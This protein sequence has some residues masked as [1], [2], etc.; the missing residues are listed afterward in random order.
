MNIVATIAQELDKSE[1]QIQAAI[2]LLD[3]GA[4]VPFIARYRKEQTNGLDDT[5]LRSLETRLQYLREFNERK[6]QIL[7]S[8]TEQEKL[9]PDLKKAIDAATSK[10]QLEDLYLPFKPKRRSKA[11]LAKEAGLAPL[12]FALLKDPNLSPDKEATK[13]LN[14][15]KGIETTELAL[16][17]AKQILMEHFSEDAQLLDSLRSYLWDN[18][19]IESLVVKGKETEGKKFSDYFAYREAIKQIPSHRALAILRGRREGLLSLNLV[20]P[21]TLATAEPSTPEKIIAAHFKLQDENR[22]ADKWLQTVVRWAWKIKLM[23]SFELELIQKRRQIAE[24]EAIGVFAEN[25]RALLLSSPAG[26]RVTMGLDPGYR[27]GVKIAI[28]DKTGKLLHY[29]NIFPH[30]PQNAWAKSL[31]TLAQLAQQYQVNLISIGN[32]TASRETEKL[33][34]ELM[35]QY[36]E[37][38]LHKLLISEAGASVYSASALAAKEFPDVDVSYRGAISIARRTQDPLAELVKIEPKAIGVGQYQHDVDQRQLAES[39]NRIVEDCVNL[40]GV[41]LNTASTALLSHIS[42]LNERIAQ[43]IVAYRENNGVFTERADLLK[44]PQLGP[45]T[46]EQ[47]AG[48]LR[49]NHGKNPLDSSAVHPESYPIVEQMLTDLQLSMQKLLENTAALKN[50]SPQKYVNE[51]CGMPTIIDIMKELEKPGRDPRADFKLP[52]FQ[53]GLNDINDLKLGMVLEGVVSNVTNFG[54]FINIGVHQDGLVHISELCDQFIKDPRSIIKVGEIIKVKVIEIDLARKRIQLSKRLQTAEPKK[55]PAFTNKEK[56]ALA[57]ETQNTKARTTRKASAAEQ[58]K[59]TSDTTATKNTAL[60]NALST[61]LA[62][63]L[64]KQKDPVN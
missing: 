34:T 30:Q 41:D 36:P 10:T 22:P 6:Q 28:V 60:P 48:F 4:T 39:L 26:M 31:R 61:A 64:G 29:S 5:I 42:G 40:V 35:Q 33:V 54:A 11:L 50:L 2:R 1:Q 43:N 8:I 52:H 49:I 55:N 14:P 21:E 63:A 47:A 16:E 19:L 46:F 12:A 53:E 45:K 25:L 15:E 57:P 58:T 13:F 51:N 59:K 32:G 9:T 56:S 27:T 17:G 7:K 23:L 24:T 3:D 62:N 20:L 37:L 38:K 44:V 18:A